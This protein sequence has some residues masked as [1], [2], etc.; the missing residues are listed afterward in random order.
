M[1]AIL[2]E[3]EGLIAAQH[4]GRDYDS[5]VDGAKDVRMKLLAGIPGF[6]AVILDGA[7]HAYATQ[8]GTSTMWKLEGVLENMDEELSRLASRHRGGYP[9]AYE[10]CF[11]ARRMLREL[12]DAMSVVKARDLVTAEIA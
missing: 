10:L 2:Q 7:L 12:V 5:L 3:A 8:R 6:S 4:A 9:F 1:Q 11:R